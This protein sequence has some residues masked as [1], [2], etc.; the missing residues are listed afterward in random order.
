MI[1]YKLATAVCSLAALGAAYDCFG[2]M[3]SDRC[4]NDAGKR[5]LCFLFG[6]AALLSAIGV[7]FR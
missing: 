3:G 1:W 4:A 6:A 2:L 7:W 5:V